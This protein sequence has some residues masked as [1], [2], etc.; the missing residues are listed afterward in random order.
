MMLMYQLSQVI[1]NNIHT[2]LHQDSPRHFSSRPQC[3]IS[4]DPFNIAKS[5]LKFDSLERSVCSQITMLKL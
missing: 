3:W 4:T 1:F 2:S 5:K